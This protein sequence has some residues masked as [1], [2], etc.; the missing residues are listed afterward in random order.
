[1]EKFNVSVILPIKSGSAFDF[2]EYFVKAITSLKE[3]KTQI[4][5]LLELKYQKSSITTIR[6]YWETKPY[7]MEEEVMKINLEFR[8][9]NPLASPLCTH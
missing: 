3:Q 6:K 1:M 9:L 7:N 2:D 4:N 8:D 5:E